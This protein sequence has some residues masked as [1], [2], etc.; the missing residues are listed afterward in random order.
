MVIPSA[1]RDHIDSISPLRNAT[2]EALRALFAPRK[3]SRREIFVKS[4]RVAT[5]VGLL[6]SGYVRS[7]F[8]TE[9]GAEYNKHM[10]VAPS[11]IG[12]YASLLS[13]RPVR[14]PQ[15]ALTPCAVW[16]ADYRRI[17]ELERRF[18]DLRRLARRFAEAMYLEKEERELEMA[19]MSAKERYLKL[20]QRYP[21]MEREIPQYEIASYLGVTATQLSRVR[22]RL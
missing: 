10:F 5:E 18:D 8:V 19:T 12:D 17:L 16:V 22:A 2:W 4:G 6:E 21:E 14:L 3:L 7:F 1:L 20:R 15:Q 9:D 13:G 11:V